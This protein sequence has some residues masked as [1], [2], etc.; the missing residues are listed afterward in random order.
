MPFDWKRDFIAEP[1]GFLEWVT[2]PFLLLQAAIFGI[3]W[4]GLAAL[5]FVAA[6]F[7]IIMFVLH[8]V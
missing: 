8:Y 3:I 1:R 6:I 5:L 2:A 4:F 7:G